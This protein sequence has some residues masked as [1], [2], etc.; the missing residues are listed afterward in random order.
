MLVF[1]LGLIGLLH[2]SCC[3]GC[4]FIHSQVSFR[5]RGWETPGSTFSGTSCHFRVALSIVLTNNHMWLLTACIVTN[6][7]EELDIEFSLNLNSHTWLAATV[8][9]STDVEH[10]HLW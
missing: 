1:E 3:H 2:I 10:F 4:R 9:Y 7:T 5:G 8:L 6:V